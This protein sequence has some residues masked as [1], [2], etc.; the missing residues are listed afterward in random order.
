MVTGGVVAA[1]GAGADVVFA[2]GFGSERSMLS[3]LSLAGTAFAWIDDLA[4]AWRSG[5]FLG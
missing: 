2:L 4:L 1:V 5:D 3:K